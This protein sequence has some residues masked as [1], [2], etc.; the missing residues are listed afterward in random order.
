M[1]RH[2]V[3]ILILVFTCGC[4]GKQGEINRD[5]PTVLQPFPGVVV[6]LDEPCVVI[7]GV[8]C[9]REGYLEQ[10][11]CT[12]GTREH[13]SLFVV[14]V[15]P[16]LVH[17]ALLLAGFESGSPGTWSSVSGKFHFVAPR[18]DELALAVRFVTPQGKTDEYPLRE[19][20]RDHHTQAIF[21]EIPW[22]FAGSFFAQNDQEMEPGEHYV[23]DL[24]GSIIGLVT[25]GDEVIGL[26]EVIADAAAV[27]PP[28]WEVN[29]KRMPPMGTPVQLIIRRWNCFDE[30][31]SNSGERSGS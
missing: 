25:F 8:C 1:T 26:S 19:L 23:A 6:N 16:S 11:A 22:V 10:I 30:D 4:V 29:E 3:I 7:D 18:G 28:L 27:H 12:P 15:E 9:L 13:E 24:T 5:S 2:I 17:A 14:Q 31:D 20:I 21:P